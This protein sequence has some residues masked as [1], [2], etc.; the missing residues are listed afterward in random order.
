VRNCVG[1]GRE[2]GNEI[3]PMFSEVDIIC[4][5]CVLICVLMGGQPI[6]LMTIKHQDIQSAIK[7]LKINAWIYSL[8]INCKQS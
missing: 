5:F 4:Y 3:A 6:M 8:L 2:G 7:I 1:S